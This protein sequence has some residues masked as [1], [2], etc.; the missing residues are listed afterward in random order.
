[1]R[2]VEPSQFSNYSTLKNKKRRLSWKFLPVIAVLFVGLWLMFGSRASSPPNLEID[3]S[4]QP[5][6]NVQGDSNQD[7]VAAVQD[8]STEDLPPT[9]RVFSDNEFKVFYDNLLL[10]NLTRVENPP[11]ISGNDIADARI[12]KLAEDRGY[13][14]RS[15]PTVALG[16]V[17]GYPLQIPVVA[18]WNSLKAAAAKA[19]LSMSIVSAYRSVDNQ[20]SLFLQRLAATGAT[21]DQV[22]EGTADAKVN[23]V[24]IT[25][26]IPGY[27][28]HHT[29]YTLDFACAGFAFEDFKNSPCQTWIAADNYKVSKEAGFIPSYPPLADLQ[30]PDPEAWEYVWVGVD[31]LYQ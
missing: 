15:S 29:G 20:R 26:S 28:K 6:P 31:Q 30:G 4:E 19:G 22:A 9:L 17:D 18:S 13:R 8:Q 5:S 2:V 7:N 25:S 16:S 27:S 14:L 10:P 3:Q 12:R 23:E 1:M 21:I 24:L 11:S